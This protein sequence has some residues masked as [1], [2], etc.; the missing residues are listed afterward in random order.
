LENRFV[1]RIVVALAAVL[2][3]GCGGGETPAPPPSP[4]RIVE[5]SPGDGTAGVGVNRTIAIVFDRAIDNASVD[6]AAVTLSP[7]VPGTISLS[8]N[9]IRFKP[10]SPLEFD[11]TYLLSVGPGVRDLAGTPMGTSS[12]FGFRTSVIPIWEGSRPFATASEDQATCTARGADGNVFVA[13]KSRGAIDNGLSNAGGHDL[14]VARFGPTGNRTWMREFGAS[15]DDNASGIALDGAGNVYVCGST[16]GGLEGVPTAGGTDA[17]VAKYDDNGV[18]LW[19]RQFGSA[20]DDFAFGVAVDASGNVYAAGATYGSVDNTTPSAGGADMMLLRYDTDGNLQW[21]RQRGTPA[22][23]VG[24]G[25]AV[26]ASGD[27]WV[28]GTTGGAFDGNAA[29]GGDD[30]FLIGFDSSGNRVRSLQFGSQGSDAAAGVAIDESG[31]IYVTGSS[32]GSYGG[33][34]KG[35]ADVVAAKFSPTGTLRWSAQFGSAGN[36][37]ALGAPA[38]AMGNLYVAGYTD[39]TLGASAYGLRD[40]FLQKVDAATGRPV[41]VRQYGTAAEDVGTGVALDD[42]GDVFL[43]GYTAGAFDGGTPAGL[44]DGFLVKYR[45]DGERQ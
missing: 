26:D 33:I 5:V 28:C 25:V 39:G 13:G 32:Y 24:M 18:R 44:N 2:L 38:V 15:G 8:G 10:L 21:A 3:A 35:N 1:K 12:T 40:L 34:S 27:G 11:R 22:A 42:V 6:N 9:V 37:A 41:W 14:F 36:D 23:D 17:F 4:P 31:D 19:V 43:S 20:N 7:S 45:A 30:M 29:R 16:A